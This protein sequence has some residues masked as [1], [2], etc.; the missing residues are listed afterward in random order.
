[1]SF[2]GVVHD[3]HLTFNGVEYYRD[4][5]GAVLLGAF[6]EKKTPAPRSEHV[7]AHGRLPTGK[8]V[9]RSS[10]AVEFDVGRTRPDD[11][12]TESLKSGARKLVRL[13]MLLPDVKVAVNGTPAVLRSLKSYGW[14]AR[15]VH[16]VIAI[17]EPAHADA[18]ARATGFRLVGDDGAD[19][20]TVGVGAATVTL[21]AATTFAYLLC[22][23]DWNRSRTGV[24]RFVDEPWGV[25]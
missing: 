19:E 17:L 4:G 5:A 20:L 3:D 15:V 12:A 9:V 2:V 21:T 24:E 23:P 16:H 7:L 13:E 14:E 11:L 10:S 6:G 1:V 8:L 25:E 22:R 18:L